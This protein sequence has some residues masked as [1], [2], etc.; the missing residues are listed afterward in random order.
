MPTYNITDKDIRDAQQFLV[1][2]QTEQVPESDLSIGSSVRDFL[3]DG[4][5]AMYAYLRGEI[6]R[7][8]ARQSLLRIQEELTDDDDISQAVDEILSNF[9]VTR[10]SGKFARLTARFHFTESQS[11]TIPVAS[12]FWRTNSLVFYVDSDTDP[13][14]IT[15]SSLFPQ[16]D[17]SGALV[18]YVV[19]VP[20]VAARTGDAYNVEPGRFV[21]ADVPGGLPYFSYLEN[22]EEGS[23][24]FSVE[25]SSD[26]IERAET[27]ISVRNLINNRSNDVTLK[28][29]FA[30]IDATLTIGMGETEMVRDRRPELAQHLQIHFGGHYDTYLTLPVVE[31]EETGIIGGYFVRPDNKINVFRD[32]QLTYELATTFTSLG[33][34]PGHILHIRNGLL[35]APQGFTITKVTDHELEVSI[36]TPFPQASDEQTTNAVVYSI[37]WLSP[38]FEEIELEAGVYYRT[39][40]ASALPASSSVPYGTSRRI[41]ETGTIVLS[42]RPVQDVVWVEIADPPAGSELID[43]STETLVFNNRVNTQPVLPA[44]PAYTEFR[45]QVWNPLEAQSMR[46]VQLVEVGPQSAPSMYDGYTLRVVYRTFQGISDIHSYVENRNQRVAAADQLIRG[47]HP[48][49]IEAVIPYK[50]KP[51]ADT[52]LDETAAAKT[53]AAM[54]NNFDPDDDLNVSD[55]STELRLKYPDVGS[56]YDVELY[57]HLDAPDGQQVVYTTSDLVS[58]FP[59]DDN[60]VSWENEDE[61]TF[62]DPVSDLWVTPLTP[63]EKLQNWFQYLGVSDRTVHYRTLA[64]FISFEARS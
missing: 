59:Q 20:L 43:P 52:E 8:A 63:A 55:F 46:A 36:N 27:A 24:G 1:Q 28:Q 3:V 6:D 10:Q 11:F 9:F 16:F 57:Y 31:R 60:S 62:P 22:V 5:A 7:V 21:R 56:V 33:V 14:V 54:V 39:A 51:T 23:N 50:M 18:D 38:A 17:S 25:S 48:V 12:Q 34:Q 41:Q 32:P 35:G 13:Y 61:I 53:I 29:E 44:E 64:D 49:W 47:R 40:A 45:L 58:I 42:G 2:F 30:E 26:F 37:G 19:N 15:E 4:F